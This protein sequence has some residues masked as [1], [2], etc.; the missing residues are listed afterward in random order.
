MR[1][2]FEALMEVIEIS[3][4]CEANLESLLKLE[5]NGFYLRTIRKGKSKP[6]QMYYVISAL[7]KDS[8]R[9]KDEELAL[10][11]YLKVGNKTG[12]S[13]KEQVNLNLGGYEIA[14]LYK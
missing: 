11:Y 13:I 12:L 7:S 2:C 10:M 14:E 9:T 4:K 6:D 8:K 3:E 1:G 5:D